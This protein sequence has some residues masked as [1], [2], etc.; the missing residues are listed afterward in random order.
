MCGFVN[1]RSGVQSPQPAPRKCA[2]LQRFMRFLRRGKDGHS[3]EKQRSQQARNQ[4]QLFP[5]RSILGVDGA[6]SA[7]YVP[8]MSR[9]KKL[10]PQLQLAAG[11]VLGI[12]AAAVGLAIFAGCLWLFDAVGIWHN[13]GPWLPHLMDIG[14][15][16]GLRPI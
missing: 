6:G 16:D 15:A 10:T 2:Y 13:G 8:R 4:A 7:V 11:I 9:W 3:G 14:D 12:L 5:P 1:Q